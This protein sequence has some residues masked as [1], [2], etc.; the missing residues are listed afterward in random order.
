[1]QHE[2][3]QIL[4]RTQ[5]CGVA[6]TNR[7]TRVVK[8]L[9]MANQLAKFTWNLAELTQPLRDLLCKNNAWSWGLAQQEAITCIKE[10]LSKTTTLTLYNPAADMEVSAGAYLSVLEQCYCKRRVVS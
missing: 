5:P 10:E 7:D 4:R 2:F 3:V 9:G 1:M 6:G 8:I